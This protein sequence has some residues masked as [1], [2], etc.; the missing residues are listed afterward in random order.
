MTQRCL[1][2]SLLCLL[3]LAGGGSAV[4]SGQAPAPAGVHRGF[5]GNHSTLFSLREGEQRVP[6]GRFAMPLTGHDSADSARRPS[7]GAVTWGA[8]LGGVV[9]FAAG[10]LLTPHTHCDACAVLFS[11][12]KKYFFWGTV[13]GAFVGGATGWYLSARR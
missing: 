11:T 13:S 4:A 7:A 12:Q 2:V 3:L 5:P 10:G 9:G 8:V 1:L 6:L